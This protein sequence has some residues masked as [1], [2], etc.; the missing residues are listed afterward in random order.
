MQRF[1]KNSSRK[2]LNSVGLAFEKDFAEA[3]CMW[4]TTLNHISYHLFRKN[5]SMEVLKNLIQLLILI[6]SDGNQLINDWMSDWKNK[7]AK[8]EEM[9]VLNVIC[10]II[11][12]EQKKLKKELDK[13]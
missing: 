13:N 7:T 12:K 9:K 1:L 11:I 3:D 5:T 8:K 6:D 10:P 2:I 4:V